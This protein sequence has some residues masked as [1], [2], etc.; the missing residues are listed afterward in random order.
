MRKLLS[1]IVFKKLN[2][3]ENKCLFK[4]YLYLFL[5]VCLMTLNTIIRIKQNYMKYTVF[6]KTLH[7]VRKTLSVIL[8]QIINKINT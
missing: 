1:V 5:F 2:P 8:K 6:T 3:K 4:M 7:T